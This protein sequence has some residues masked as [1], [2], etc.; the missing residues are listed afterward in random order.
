MGAGQNNL[1]LG[2]VSGAY[3]EVISNK[4]LSI[5]NLLKKEDPISYVRSINKATNGNVKFDESELF[6]VIDIL[7]KNGIENYSTIDIQSPRNL[8]EHLAY[9]DQAKKVLDEVSDATGIRIIA[10]KNFDP[11]HIFA[12]TIGKWNDDLDALLYA[13]KEYIPDIKSLALRKRKISELK[14]KNSLPVNIEDFDKIK[15]LLTE[16]EAKVSQRLEAINKTISDAEISNLETSTKFNLKKEAE[17]NELRNEYNDLV[18]LQ[19]KF[20]TKRSDIARVREN[21]KFFAASAGASGFLIG[22]SV[23]FAKQLNLQKERRTKLEKELIEKGKKRREETSK[24]KEYWN[25][26]NLDQE[27]EYTKLNRSLTQKQPKEKISTNFGTKNYGGKI[28]NNWLQK[29]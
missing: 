17:V 13:T 27:D 14:Q 11:N 4:Q 16:A 12:A 23:P 9:N 24:F 20:I 21:M 1:Q 22:A 26:N 15:N 25:Q 5:E 7:K 6:K 3:G 10:T 19:Y 8:I 18:D 28:T 29:Y 2:T